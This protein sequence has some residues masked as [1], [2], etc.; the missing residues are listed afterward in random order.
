MSNGG[1]MS[2]RL[3]CEAAGLFLGVAPVAG[4][5]N[6][7]CAPSQAISVL[8]IHGTADQNVL[9][10]GGAP[11]QR[12]DP[13]PRVDASVADSVGSFVD[14]NGCAAKPATSSPDTDGLVIVTEE[15]PDCTGGARVVLH[16]IECG[17]HEWPGDQRATVARDFDASSAIWDFF[18][19][20]PPR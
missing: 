6:V 7:D 10:E 20:L 4:A 12:A 14:S 17:V 1:M 3:A 15:W 9:Y 2:Y 5:L 8:A 11:I 19:T 16:T 13:L 18:S